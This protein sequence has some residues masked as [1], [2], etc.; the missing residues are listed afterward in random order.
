MANKN[1]TTKRTRGESTNNVIRDILKKYYVST[2]VFEEFVNFL[3]RSLNYEM[4]EMD[5]QAEKALKGK[6]EPW[7]IFDLTPFYKQY[8]NEATYNITNPDTPKPH[9]LSFDSLNRL[10]VLFLKE[11]PA[12]EILDNFNISY[13]T[14]KNRIDHFF[15]VKMKNEGK[16]HVKYYTPKPDVFTALVNYYA[17]EKNLKDNWNYFK[18][19][20]DLFK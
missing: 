17:L 19:I 4:P 3:S 16:A 14:L 7:E 6:W 8:S 1:T 11:I 18:Q 12:K 20:Y 9:G 2:K 5:I 13:P 15:I 10:R